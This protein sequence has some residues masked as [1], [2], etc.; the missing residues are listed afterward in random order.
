[1]E[2]TPTHI[3]HPAPEPVPEPAPEPSAEP[4]PEPEPSRTST[5]STAA[6][7]SSS[8]DHPVDPLPVYTTTWSQPS[9]YSTVIPTVQSSST[10]H[11]LHFHQQEHDN[12]HNHSIDENIAVTTVMYPSEQETVSGHHTAQDYDLSQKTENGTLK[13]HTVDENNSEMT[14]NHSF[15]PEVP[16]SVHMIYDDNDNA[17]N[18]ENSLRTPVQNEEL[19][20]TLSPHF[21]TETQTFIVKVT[22]VHSMTEHAGDMIIRHI[23]NES[24]RMVLSEEKEGA[25]VGWPSVFTDHEIQTEAAVIATSVSVTSDLQEHHAAMSVGIYGEHN[26]NEAKPTE[27]KRGFNHSIFENRSKDFNSSTGKDF[28]I[29]HTS[30]NSAVEPEYIYHTQNETGTDFLKLK[31]ANIP[32]RIVDAENEEHDHMFMDVHTDYDNKS[33]PD[34]SDKMASVP[35][36]QLAG[37][38][39]H[40]HGNDFFN[41][42]YFPDSER[43]ENDTFLNALSPEDYKNHPV[44]PVNV[45]AKP[46]LNITVTP[47]PNMKKGARLDDVE[48]SQMNPNQ[49]DHTATSEPNAES[50]SMIIHDSESFSQSSAAPVTQS[51]YGH[52]S[53]PVNEQIP[54]LS[55][56]NI[57]PVFIP[58]TEFAEHANATVGTFESFHEATNKST[59]V[60]GHDI[61]HDFLKSVTE[62]VLMKITLKPSEQNLTEIVNGTVKEADADSVVKESV[63]EGTSEDTVTPPVT[64]TKASSAEYFEIFGT[65]QA[66][67]TQADHVAADI[68]MKDVDITTMPNNPVSTSSILVNDLNSSIESKANSSAGENAIENGELFHPGFFSTTTELEVDHPLTVA[69]LPDHHDSENTPEDKDAVVETESSIEITTQMESVDKTTKILLH[70]QEGNTAAPSDSV[71]TQSL[72][73]ML[74]PETSPTLPSESP[75]IMTTIVPHEENDIPSSVDTNGEKTKTDTGI[76]ETSGDKQQDITKPE[77]RALTNSTENVTKTGETHFSTQYKDAAT[78][79]DSTDKTEKDSANKVNVSEKVSSSAFGVS[80]DTAGALSA[81]SDTVGSSSAAPDTVGSSSAA[82]DTVDSSSAAPDTVGTSS[83]AP[84]T[85]GSSSAAPDTLRTSSAAP[86]TVGTSS[87]A[88]DTVGSS[89]APDTLRT[90]SSASNMVGPSTAAP[91]TLGGS[92]APPDTVGTSSVAP[93]TLGSSSTAPHPAGSSLV[94]PDTVSASSA[95]PDTVGSSSASPYVMIK[96]EEFKMNKSDINN[97]ANITKEM[98]LE[99]DK[100]AALR[101][102]PLNEHVNTVKPLLL[103]ASSTHNNQEP[104]I[105][106]LSNNTGGNSHGNPDTRITDHSNS[107]FEKPHEFTDIEN[108]LLVDS[109]KIHDVAMSSTTEYANEIHALPPSGG[110]NV[111]PPTAHSAVLVDPITDEIQNPTLVG[112]VRKNTIPVTIPEGHSAVEHT[113][114]SE[115]LTTLKVDKDA[116]AITASKPEPKKKDFLNVSVNK[117]PLK[118]TGNTSSLQGEND[119]LFTDKSAASLFEKKTVD[120]LQ[121]YD[122]DNS[123]KI[124]K[125]GFA[126]FPVGDIAFDEQDDL[127]LDTDTTTPAKEM[128]ASTTFV[129]FQGANSTTEAPSLANGESRPI[130]EDDENEDPLTNLHKDIEHI[131]IV[132]PQDKVMKDKK[133]DIGGNKAYKFEGE[134]IKNENM[135]MAN[136]Q[137]V[138]ARNNTE[139]ARDEVKRNTESSLAVGIEP[140]IALGRTESSEFTDSLLT[141]RILPAG[142]NAAPKISMNESMSSSASPDDDKMMVTRSPTDEQSL[143]FYSQNTSLK[144]LDGNT[145]ENMSINGTDFLPSMTSESSDT[146]SNIAGNISV[147][148][149]NLG[150]LMSTIQEDGSYSVVTTA[151]P[152]VLSTNITSS[153]SPEVPAGSV[154]TLKNKD[155]A[156]LHKGIVP[157]EYNW[158]KNS[159]K[160]FNTTTD[161][162]QSES[163]DGAI[164]N[165]IAESNMTLSRPAILE[166]P[167]AFSKCASGWLV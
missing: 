106:D 7:A 51:S 88:P 112:Q 8:S 133:F 103:N 40:K 166:P 9:E 65:E 140:A 63:T 165:W 163:T 80:S 16:A 115:S 123:K 104:I 47:N 155:F 129:V 58:V 87:S 147:I 85:V 13:S 44:K 144:V 90:S 113:E 32:I 158:T 69:P 138:L 71:A 124:D 130:D 55:H 68:R 136:D 18:T 59:D 45:A 3:H 2:T 66:S 78:T 12:H 20:S 76:I 50:V 145:T 159:T 39:M 162:S 151:P 108:K 146:T 110:G 61:L 77:D 120:K 137:H 31:A 6:A 101:G 14:G 102:N 67:V 35:L 95:A 72:L 4:T 164:H 37:R 81:A 111:I 60:D 116:S 73:H 109:G 121:K 64:S 107:D 89:A 114:K 148:K 131:N 49:H 79:T 142:E 161:A 86:D 26:E 92:S 84:D 82:P 135:S 24:N 62:S 156:I 128:S 42:I 139:T 153:E 91:D 125:I 22:N 134:T 52:D 34:S 43:A 141:P 99:S 149:T 57:S 19:G 15:H 152:L 27:T 41:D 33:M 94:V 53:T 117:K 157:L 23:D 28:D 83:S 1:M 122:K 36:T 54:S 25:A 132:E 143:K 5:L 21:H 98:P 10:D 17:T 119:Q 48:M 70:D 127:L 154:V 105:L 11:T 96:Y 38:E 97:S 29:A 167:T 56:D 46:V 75:N 118:F 100:E 160:E 74:T 93:G 126:A 30:G 150:I